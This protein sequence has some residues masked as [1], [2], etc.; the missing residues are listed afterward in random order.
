MVE[1][2]VP[3]LHSCRLTV[4]ACGSEVNAC[5]DPRIL[6]FVQRLRKT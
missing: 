4:I 2:P 1:H 5:E 3:Y 6:H